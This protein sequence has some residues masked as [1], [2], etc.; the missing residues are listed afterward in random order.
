[1]RIE[2]IRNLGLVGVLLPLK[3]SDGPKTYK[4]QFWKDSIGVKSNN[5]NLEISL[6]FF[7]SKLFLDKD[8]TIIVSINQKI[9]FL[10]ILAMISIGLNLFYNIQSNYQ[11]PYWLFLVCPIIFLFSLIYYLMFR[12][13]KFLNIKVIS[14]TQ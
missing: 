3:L 2:I 9:N 8:A 7:K 5:T 11:I 6:D 4:L 14:G 10:A 1:M 12:N 13:D